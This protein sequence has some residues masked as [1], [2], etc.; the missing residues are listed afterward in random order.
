M[1]GGRGYGYGMMGGRGWD[2]GF[3]CPMLGFGGGG[4]LAMLAGLALAAVLVV[5]LVVVLV[6]AAGRRHG[7]KANANAQAGTGFGP[8]SSADAA[9]AILNERYARGEIDDEEYQRRKSQLLG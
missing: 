9:L 1:M 6:R 5:L 3:D 8:H 7:M 2:N 4:W